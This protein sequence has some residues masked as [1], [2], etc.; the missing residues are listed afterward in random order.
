MRMRLNTDPVDV[1]GLDSSETAR[2]VFY[3]EKKTV[4]NC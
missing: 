1:S 3:S 2:K 4:S